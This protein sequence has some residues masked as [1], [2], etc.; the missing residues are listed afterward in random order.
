MLQSMKVVSFCH[1]L[2]GPACT[3]YLGDM[4]ADI[5]KIEPVAGERARRWAGEHIGGVSGLYLAA[6]RNKRCLAVNLKAP[7][8]LEIVW[9]L[10]DRADVLVENY[11][12]GVMDRLGLSYNAVKERKPDIIYASGTGWGSSGPMLTRAA[13]DIIIQA[14]TGLA[15]ATGAM[16]ARAAGSAIIDQHAGALLA[17][18]IV[19]AYVKKLTTGQGTRVESSLYAAGLDIQTE[20]LTVYMSCQPGTQVLDRDPH[21]ATW[22]HQAPYGIFRLKDA[23]IA[24][25][26]N[27]PRKVAEVLG[28]D[29]LRAIADIDRFAERDRYAQVFAEEMS[30]RRFADVA[31][32]FD[33]ADIWYSRVYDFD[34]VAEDPQAAALGVFRR[35]E[36]NGVPAVLVNHPIRYDAAIPPLARQAL[37][38]GEHSREI[39]REIGCS[40][41]RID[42]LLEK[43]V[44][45][46]P[47]EWE[48]QRSDDATAAV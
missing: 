34:D 23:E 14:R 25:S 5:I 44:V 29:V 21:L 39:L 45:A 27:D 24:M 28:S 37:R 16:D 1:V 36:V 7:E 47:P 26:V 12:S 43:G 30:K 42:D 31:R 18:G 8:G 19:A 48:N 38:I 41:R 17:M 46:A 40:E 2:Q 20:P 11:R 3:Q 33:A 35:I 10:I 15:R 13:Q 22:Y 9:Q 4:G 32:A 6:F